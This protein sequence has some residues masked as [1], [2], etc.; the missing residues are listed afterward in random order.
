MNNM[1]HSTEKKSITILRP[2]AF[3]IRTSPPTP[4]PRVSVQRFRSFPS[5]FH[6]VATMSDW[7]QRLAKVQASLPQET[8]EEIDHL[9]I[10]ELKLEVMT[11]GKTHLGRTYEDVWNSSPEW[12][13]WFLQHYQK[14]SKLAHRKM[15]RY[16][17]LKIEA[18]EENPTPGRQ[19]PVLPKGHA[20]P[21]AMPLRTKAK[22]QP[23][24]MM[25]P[26]GMEP[27]PEE[28]WVASENAQISSLQERMG[29][30]ENALHQILAHLAPAPMM[31]NPTPELFPTM[32]VEEEWNDPWN[33]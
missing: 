24:T 29:L 9:S 1:S 15:I 21:K 11:F 2:K 10:E 22:A 18:M 23:S 4:K 25:S 28:P 14:S 30:M 33:Q 5:R 16:I 7:T 3:T 27:P 19:S 12:T 20:A 13:Q 17:K 8:P 32:P 26:E 31:T 6:R